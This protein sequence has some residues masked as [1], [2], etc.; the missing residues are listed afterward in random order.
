MTLNSRNLQISWY[1]I[2]R[3]PFEHATGFLLVRPAPLL[4]K[5]RDPGP[6]ALVADIRHP[7][8]LQWTRSRPGFAAHDRPI[9]TL[10]QNG[11]LF[12][13]RHC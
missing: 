9:D 11:A 8:S 5:E 1:L 2:P 12:S 6:Q 3:P 10:K 13:E 7:D 4:E